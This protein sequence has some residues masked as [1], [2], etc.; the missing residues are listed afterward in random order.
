MGSMDSTLRVMKCQKVL[1]HT[2][3]LSAIYTCFL[4]SF[5]IG[6]PHGTCKSRILSITFSLPTHAGIPRYIQNRRQNMGNTTSQFLLGYTRSYLF[7]QI[8]IKR[9]PS[10]NTGRKTGRLLDK[11]SAKSLH[12][13]NRRNMMRALFHNQ[14]LHIFYPLRR[15]L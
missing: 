15:A 1:R 2:F 10:G 7:F 13:K 12:V 3:R 6:Y 5:G 9:C 4:N 14:R 8:R 11:G